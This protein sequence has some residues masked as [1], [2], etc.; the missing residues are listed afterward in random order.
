MIS[1]VLVRC[2]RRGDRVEERFESRTIASSIAS[3]AA[4]QRGARM[5][6]GGLHRG[7]GQRIFPRH[8]APA[9]GGEDR[10]GCR[11]PMPAAARARYYLG[12]MV[13]YFRPTLPR[14][15]VL[16]TIETVRRPGKPTTEDRWRVPS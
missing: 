2:L 16:T 5:S 8:D 14:Y 12:S 13:A 3:R 10:Y 15:T 4:L 7:Y 9:G 1:P 11:S 6:A